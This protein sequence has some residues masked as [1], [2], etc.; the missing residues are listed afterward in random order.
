MSSHRFLL[1]FTVLF[2]TLPLPLP[3]A[4]ATA[5]TNE[6]A[7][8]GDRMRTAFLECEVSALAKGCLSEV[9][10]ATDWQR[11]QPIYRRQLR[12]MLGLEPWPSSSA[13][14][15]QSTGVVERDDLVVEKLHFQSMPGLYVTANLYRPKAVTDPL[16]AVLYLCGHGP[17]IS[18]GV[19]Y[20]NKVTYQHHGVWF[21]RNG[22]LC[23]VLDSLQLGEIQGLHHGTYREGKWWWNARGY[24]PAGVEAWNAIR[25]L[26]YLETRPEVDR[27]RIGVTGRSGGGAYSWWV[28]A[29]DERIRAAAPVAGITDLQN[30]VVD[31]VVEGHCDCMFTVN[32]YRWDYP[33]VAALVAPRPVLI[34]NTDADG[35]FPLDGVFRTHRQVKRIYQLLGASAQC[36]LVIGPGPHQDT[37]DLQ[38]PV[39][40]WFNRH[41]KGRES[42]IEMAATKVFTPAELK[43]F[44]TLPPDAINERVDEVFVP[45][46]PVPSVP[47]PGAEWEQQR[48]AWRRGLVE[49]VFAG[50][51]V[52]AAAPQLA[53]RFSAVRDGVR[54]AAWDFDSDSSTP[55]R[56]YVARAEPGPEPRSH[57]LEVLGDDEAAESRGSFA[58]WLAAWQTAFGAEL[59]DELALNGKS[60]NAAP[61]AFDTVRRTLVEQPLALAWVAPRG[62]G[63]TAWSGDAK[64]STHMRRR[65]MLVGQTVDSLRV[66]DIRRAV[67]AL[68]TLPGWQDSRLTL[69]AEG[70]LACDALYA[71]VLEP[72]MAEL[73]LWR[74]PASH[75]IGPDY[76]N[77]LRVL[78]VPQAMALA[79]ERTRIL[80]HDVTAADWTYPQQVIAALGWPAERL[81]LLP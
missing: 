69:R 11:L 38:M 56:L 7:T 28:A 34:V 30:H 22:Y 12:E 19:S 36:G 27:Q 51:P 33:Q 53:P 60:E 32:T 24:S 59:V 5:A 31:G 35:I 75:Q 10:S 80:L 73:E 47:K 40:R 65:L 9:K 16:P 18:N 76:L 29:L 68:K 8:R 77:V 15:A 61:A 23:L 4:S 14:L 57:I 37:Q 58:R 54:F 49:K 41:L 81:R 48:E 1:V 26:D 63:L 13:L 50:W 72:G 74:L 79:T 78:D 45:R 44:S 43:V 71:A 20:G 46:A 3:G 64:Q 39:F 21:A 70:T 66:W 6:P 67:S 2:F 55:L 42:L 17:V 25:A 52:N 62:L